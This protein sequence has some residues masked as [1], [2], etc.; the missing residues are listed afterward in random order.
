[1]IEQHLKKEKNRDPL[2]SPNWVQTRITEA[3]TGLLGMMRFADFD[4]PLLQ[5]ALGDILIYGNFKQNAYHLAAQAYQIGLMESPADPASKRLT[6]KLSGA[7]FQ[8]QWPLAE[9]EAN[10]KKE[11]LKGEQL[12]Q[13]VAADEALWISQGKDASAMFMS[14]YFK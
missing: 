2:N 14:K 3:T 12:F 9:V 1:M 7:A 10:V 5:E 8:A 11:L 4:N 13:A 6:N